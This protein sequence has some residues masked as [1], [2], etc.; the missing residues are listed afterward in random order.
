M[1]EDIINDE[2]F[3]TYI[4][5]LEE[6]QL[7]ADEELGPVIVSDMTKGWRRAAEQQ[8]QGRGFRHGGRRCC[9]CCCCCC[10]CSFFFFIIVIVVVVVVVV[11]VVLF[12]GGAVVFGGTASRDASE[13]PAYA[14]RS[15]E[16][17]AGGVE[18]SVLLGD[19]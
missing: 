10:C 14:G 11:V 17:G 6:K 1:V 18:A 7:I 9:C 2:P 12:F 8:Q 3:T 16:D 19:V 15:E 13:A 5:F 4:T